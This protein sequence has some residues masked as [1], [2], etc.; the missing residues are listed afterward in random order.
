MHVQKC[1]FS[2][3]GGALE[4]HTSTLYIILKGF[5][6]QKPLENAPH[7]VSGSIAWPHLLEFYRRSGSALS[8]ILPQVV[9]R[10]LP[11]AVATLLPQ[12]LST[13]LRQWKKEEGRRKKDEREQKKD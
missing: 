3:T 4:P 2:Y 11:Q 9:S 5:R 7:G 13:F 10:M 8:R 12:V 6:T 1:S